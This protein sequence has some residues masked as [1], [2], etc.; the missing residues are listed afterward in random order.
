MENV[1]FNK[2]F[3]QVINKQISKWNIKLSCFVK[4]NGFSNKFNK[5]NDILFAYK[6]IQ[7]SSQLLVPEKKS[8]YLMV[9]L[10]I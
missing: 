4:Y 8:K 7:T 9:H 6:L 10:S 3:G 2:Q 1:E 5:Q